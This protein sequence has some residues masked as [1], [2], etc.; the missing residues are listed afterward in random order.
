M[1]RLY[2][3]TDTRTGEQRLIEAS[4]PA[5]AVRVVASRYVAAPA[6][7]PEVVA[8]YERGIKV[9]RGNGTDSTDLE[10]AELRG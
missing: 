6:S 2:V 9:E 3:V 10:Q 5:Q 1:S 7:A 8:L 4:N